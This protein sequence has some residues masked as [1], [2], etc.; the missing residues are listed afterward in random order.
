MSSGPMPLVSTGSGGDQVTLGIPIYNDLA[1]CAKN[2]ADGRLGFGDFTSVLDVGLGILNTALNPIGAL[3]KAPLDFLLQWIVQ[4]VEPLD[5]AL[6]GLL[7]D[8]HSIEQTAKA[9]VDAAQEISESANRYVASLPGIDSWTGP[10]ADAYREAVR[11]IHL[12]FS[13]AASSAADVSGFVG[14]AGGLVAAFR[15]FIWDMLVT[16]LSEVITAALV[17]LASAVPSFGASIAAFTGWFSARMAMIAGR[18]S[19]TLSKLLTKLGD[20][21]QKLGLSRTAFDSAAR[22]LREIARRMGQSASRGFGQSGIGRHPTLPGDGRQDFGRNMPGFSD[23]T[24][25]YGNIKRGTDAMDKGAENH[26]A[27][28]RTDIED[29]PEGY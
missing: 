2:L 21:A 20:L 1:S 11:G 25:D 5:E 16:F 13:E 9:W 23:R 24:G 7:G 4:N 18:F 19:K 28:G 22:S 14:L 6:N 17:A 26:D 10:A 15:A 12:T 29:L 27:A 8:P 3:V